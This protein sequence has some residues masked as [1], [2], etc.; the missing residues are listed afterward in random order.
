M[1]ILLALFFGGNIAFLGA[2]GLVLGAIGLLLLEVELDVDVY[3]CGH[4]LILVVII[5]D[6][7][8]ALHA[9]LRRGHQHHHISYISQLA[10]NAYFNQRKK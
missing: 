5:I 7:V 8:V 2:T 9:P 6:V 3:H 1:A 10:V 4:L